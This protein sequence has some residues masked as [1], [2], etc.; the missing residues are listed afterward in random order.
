MRY[1]ITYTHNRDL[2]Y[3]GQR[4]TTGNDVT[5]AVVAWGDNGPRNR[6]YLRVK[7]TA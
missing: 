3:V 6:S 5:D 4:R 2:M 1:G 7:A